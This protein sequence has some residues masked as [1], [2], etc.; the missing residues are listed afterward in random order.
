MA[1]IS[2]KTPNRALSFLPI[3]FWQ[4]KC[5]YSCLKCNCKFDFPCLEIWHMLRILDSVKSAAV[6]SITWKYSV[7]NINLYIKVL[8]KYKYFKT[9]FRLMYE[10]QVFSP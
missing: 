2:Y 7:G 5:L 10:K 3:F 1:V 9:I 4:E 6:Q 8:S